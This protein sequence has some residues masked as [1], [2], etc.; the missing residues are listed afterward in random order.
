MNWLNEL[1]DVIH[2]YAVMRS[3]TAEWYDYLDWI[4]PDEQ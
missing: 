1:M 2:C 3:T 4:A